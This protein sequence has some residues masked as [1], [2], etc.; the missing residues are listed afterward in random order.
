M[1]FS[2]KRTSVPINEGGRNHWIGPQSIRRF[3]RHRLKGPLQH[4]CRH[5]NILDLG[6]Y[7][8]SNWANTELAVLPQL[9]IYKPKRGNGL[10]YRI[11][12]SDYAS[13]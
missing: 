13:R 5:K 7:L 10:V 12:P 8:W 1:R 3:V 9:A 2:R 4:Q 11:L 6:L